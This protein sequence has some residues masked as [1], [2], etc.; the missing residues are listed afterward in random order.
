MVSTA[1]D[2]SPLRA[3]VADYLGWHALRG[4]SARHRQDVHRMLLAFAQER[5]RQSRA[6]A[7]TGGGHLSVLLAALQP[8]AFG[9]RADLA[10]T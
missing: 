4:S 1:P 10:M 6:A 8:G 3:A 2:P 7:P 5:P 9:H